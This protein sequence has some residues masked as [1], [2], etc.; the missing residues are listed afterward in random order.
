DCTLVAGDFDYLL[1]VRVRDM[2]DFNKLH[3]EK[4]IALPGVRQTRTFFVMKVVKENARLA[5]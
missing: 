5:F 3:G 4:L 1:K 2:S